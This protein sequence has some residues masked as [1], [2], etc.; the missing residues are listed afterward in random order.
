MTAEKTRQLKWCKARPIAPGTK[1]PMRRL[2]HYVGRAW[3]FVATQNP[4]EHLVINK[5]GDVPKFFRDA[6]KL[7]QYGELKMEVYDIEGCYPNMPKE[8]IRFAMR[9]IVQRLEREQGRKGEASH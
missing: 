1:H 2:L 5:T 7:H 8:T 6:E 9:S 3:S 4:G